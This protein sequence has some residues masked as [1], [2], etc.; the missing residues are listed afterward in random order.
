M[1][2]ASRTATR[3]W[4]ASAVVL[5]V[6][7]LWVALVPQPALAC[8][9]AEPPPPEQAMAEADAVF[10]GEVAETRIVGDELTGDLIARISVDTVWKGDVAETVEVRTA[11]DTAMCGYH[12]IPGDRDLVYARQAE[13]GTYSTHLCTRSAPLERADDDLT[14]LGEGAEPR[15]GEQVIPGSRG[16]PWIAAI[17]AA[18]LTTIAVT[19][20][21][22]RAA[23]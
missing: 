13:D 14:A 7:A 10:A 12:F 18:A 22:R 11:T 4:P 15:A 9:C 20:R 19:W 2:D 23:P 16:W 17:A 8:D 21:L 3:W 1:T 5:I 6:A